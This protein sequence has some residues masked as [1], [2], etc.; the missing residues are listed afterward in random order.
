MLRAVFGML[1]VL[2]LIGLVVAMVS[3]GEGMLE[4]SEWVLL[5]TAI[6]MISGVTFWFVSP[7]GQQSFDMKEMGIK[8]SGGAA[9]GASFMLLAYF[10]TPPPVL[11]RYSFPEDISNS[12]VVSLVSAGNGVDILHV[13]E[14]RKSLIVEFKEG[15]SEE[16]IRF[17]H[18]L[19]LE[20]LDACYLIYRKGR[21]KSC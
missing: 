12:Y 8:L 6:A 15:V 1:F 20:L 3:S 9:V 2:V 11:Q 14:D 17:K 13:D 5:Y 18:A 7:D 4:R 16:K 19:G 10:I 21:I